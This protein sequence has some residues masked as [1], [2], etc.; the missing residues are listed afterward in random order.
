MKSLIVLVLAVSAFVSATAFA[1][2]GDRVDQ[3]FPQTP[4]TA[5]VPASTPVVTSDANLPAAF[6]NVYFGQ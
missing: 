1:D 2:A 4:V 6:V 5:S 3:V